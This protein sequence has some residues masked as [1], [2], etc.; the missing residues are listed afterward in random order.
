M[1]TVTGLGAAMLLG[2]QLSAGAIVAHAK[3]VDLAIEDL[4]ANVTMTITPENG[5]EKRRA[6]RLL[7]RREGV[8]YRALITL[9][10]PPEMNGTR[11]LVVASRGERNQQWAYFPDLDLVRQIAGR[12]QDASF[13]G[14]DIT[15]S[16]LAGGAH[17]DDLVHR[18]LGEEEVDGVPCYVLEGVPR[19]EIVYG[20]LQGWVRK[21]NFVTIRA[22]FFDKEGARIKE[23]RM[24]D[25]RTVDGVPLAH[26]IEM[27]S[28]VAK[29]RT[30]LTIAEPRINV[31]LAPDLFREES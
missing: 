6:F 18:L 15:Y 2:S 28:L 13:L 22:A 21:D 16:D 25:V 11:F 9:L 24:S 3:E 31:D 4:S 30:V 8:N 12:D 7:M 5:Q 17:L 1:M 23:A 19:H 27:T 10:E 14:S 26:R 29:S 20:K